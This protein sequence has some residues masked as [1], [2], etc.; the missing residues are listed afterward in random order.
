MNE[1]RTVKGEN[2][3]L[4]AA[5]V[6]LMLLF[7]IFGWGKLT[8][9]SGTLQYMIHVGAPLPPLATIVAIVMEFFVP[10]AIILGLATRPL[11]IL[12]AIYTLGTGIIAHH[13]WTMTGMA[14][15]ENEINFWKNISI[16]AGLILLY[17]TGPGKYAI[18][19]SR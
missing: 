19:A 14:R 11:A 16:I 8:N 15:F 2:A 17:V 18:R 7:V 12:L 13:Y 5:R 9:Y 4:L 6:L 1:T 10:I 3:L